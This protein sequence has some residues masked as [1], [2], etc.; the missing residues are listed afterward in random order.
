M[1]MNER[2]ESIEDKIP[3]GAHRLARRIEEAGGRVC[4]V[5]GSLRDLLIGGPAKDYDFATDLTPERIQSIFPRSVDVGARFGT[6]I[7]LDRGQAYEITT[8]RSDG[9]YSDARHPDHVVFTNSIEEDLCR[10]DFT[11][12]AIA[13]DLIARRLIDPHEGIADL[14]RRIVRCVGRPDERFGEDALRLLRCI[15]IAGQLEFKIEENTYASLIRS[16]E[17]LAAVASERIRDE[18]NRILEQ[19]HPAVS[20]ERL[21]ET[22]LLDRFL[23]EL[24]ECYGVSQNRYHAYD[25]FYHS[26]AAV[27]HA[28]RDNRIVRLAALF[29][30]LGK[31]D[32]RREIDGRVT[33]Y[34]HQAWSARKA[35][36][37]MRR[38][39]YPN[40]ERQRVVHL[41]QQHMFHY[42][43][44]WTDSAIRR[45]MRTVGLDQL[46]DLFSTRSADSLG[47]GLRRSARS[48]E[49]EELQ[50][51]IAR[52]LEK[53][54]AL[55]V[56]D[57]EIGGRDLMNE[58]R[59]DQGPIIG[60]ILDRLLEEV[61]DDPSRNVRSAL[62]KRAAEIRPEMEHKALTRRKQ[63]EVE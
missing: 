56:R 51:R 63:R 50:D 42:G 7:V 4:L 1:S 40:E 32:A 13:F 27:D 47:N 12:N 49:L 34:N 25:V 53:E 15:R 58:L 24:S 26:L 62:L 45:F 9:L 37:I 17:G 3:E 31:V 36:A 22:G 39:R 48:V 33:F 20:F 2:M 18:L 38:L 57:L 21:F 43:S 28:P 60:L 14:E 41:I 61:L 52:M 59:I 54:T 10:R 23:P 19:L 29:H 16:A 30:D 44:E 35:N 5:G 11:I 8:F 46:G 55:S 6:I